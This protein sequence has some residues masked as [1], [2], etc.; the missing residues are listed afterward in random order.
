MSRAPG[1]RSRTRSAPA[2]CSRTRWR[3]ACTRGTPRWSRVAARSSRSPGRA[4]TSPRA[5][6]SPPSTGCPSSPGFG[7][8]AGRGIHTDR[9]R[10]GRR[11]DEDD[12][13]PRDPAGGPPGLGR[14]RR[15]EPRPRERPPPARVHVRARSVLPAD[16]VDRREREHE[17]RRPPLPRVRRD[18]EPRPGARRRPRGRRRRAPGL[19]GPRGGRLRPARRHGGERG[20]ARGRGGG[21]RSAHAAPRRCGR[22]CSTSRPSRTAR[23]P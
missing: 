3:S 22:C 6:A 2:R 8:G 10:A 1:E 5:S 11:D 9:R 20:D 19:G 7:H 14:A 4:T 16:L 15:P 13:H 23:P 18:V 21:V 17:R 12:G